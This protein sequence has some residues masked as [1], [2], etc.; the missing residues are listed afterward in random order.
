MFLN[1][2]LRI[3]VVMLALSFAA[4][5]APFFSDNIKGDWTG[6][7]SIVGHTADATMKFDVD[8]DKLTGTVF[9]E[10]TGLGTVTDGV[11]KGSKFKCTLKFEKHEAIVMTGEILNDKLA[12]T[13]T[14]EGNSGTWTASRKK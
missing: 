10:H 3:A 5:S 6:V 11:V 8:G 4:L 9:T 2:T 7:F 14:T 13:F 12:G 1:R